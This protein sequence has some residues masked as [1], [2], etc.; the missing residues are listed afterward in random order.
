M[1][2]RVLLITM[3]II[4]NSV[5]A[6]FWT[7]IYY[8][9]INVITNDSLSHVGK[10]SVGFNSQEEEDIFANTIKFNDTITDFVIAKR[11]YTDVIQI[12]T[13]AFRTI[14]FYA[15]PTDCFIDIRK[16]DI[17][18]I[19]F[20]SY[21][22]YDDLGSNPLFEVKKSDI[23][24][25]QNFK[26]IK[27]EHL[28]ISE[29][30]TY[31]TFYMNDLDFELQKDVFEIQKRIFETKKTGDINFKELFRKGVIVVVGRTD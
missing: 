26:P 25:L 30:E 8:L 23:E 22:K 10:L 13:H 2:I 24:E 5:K 28:N 29:I 12:N 17:L 16:E 14:G 27:V 9:R 6:E 4:S 19:V 31:F 20:L 3:I 18:K 15:F 1:K 11:Y 7:P 21:E